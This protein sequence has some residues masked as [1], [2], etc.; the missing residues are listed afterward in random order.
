M[1]ESGLSCAVCGIL[2]CRYLEESGLFL[3]TLS[4][5]AS[6][7]FSFVSRVLFM[8]P[9]R[10]ATLSPASSGLVL[11]LGCVSVLLSFFFV[12]VLRVVCQIGDFVS[13]PW[14]LDSRC[15]VRLCALLLCF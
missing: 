10:L 6:V 4:E 2:D 12:C 15:R 1:E 3:A 11:F 9:I 8:S 7:L 14:P 5:C 13:H